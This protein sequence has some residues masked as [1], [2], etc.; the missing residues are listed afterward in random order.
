[1]AWSQSANSLSGPAT[2]QHFPHPEAHSDV[3]HFLSPPWPTLTVFVSKLQMTPEHRMAKA[4][5][6]RRRGPSSYLSELT[7]P[8]AH[9]NPSSFCFIRPR[10]T[11]S[12]HSNY[13][14]VHFHFPN[15]SL[16]V[17]I[18]YSRI[19]SHA[20]SPTNPALSS[21]HSSCLDRRIT[22]HLAIPHL[23]MPFPSTSSLRAYLSSNPKNDGPL[24]IPGT[25]INTYAD[26]F[27]PLFY[28]LLSQYPSLLNVGRWWPSYRA[29]G[30]HLSG[31]AASSLRS[32]HRRH[33]LPSPKLLSSSL[34]KRNAK[35]GIPALPQSNLHGFVVGFVRNCGLAV[36][37]TCRLA[38]L[39]YGLPSLSVIATPHLQA[40]NLPYELMSEGTCKPG[41][42]PC[43]SLHLAGANDRNGVSRLHGI[44]PYLAYRTTGDILGPLL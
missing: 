10:P 9:T 33:P 14:T 5:S 15:Q 32:T 27:V 35:H 42:P 28:L 36:V 41:G 16:T 29:F 26:N 23:T 25:S 24:L 44:I 11:P 22:T 38:E 39:T 43:F 19:T 8:S 7:T 40:Y 34:F 21:T 30:L 1:M 4:P 13:S 3:N 37:H 2:S 6:P 31:A 18:T 17:A 20:L 12:Y